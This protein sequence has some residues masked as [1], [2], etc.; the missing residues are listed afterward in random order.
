MSRRILPI[1]WITLLAVLL[2]ACGKPVP[3]DKSAYVGDWQSATMMLRIS[4]EGRVAYR[5]VDGNTRTSVDAPL[6]GFQGDDFKA[7]L[8]PIATT[9]KVSAPPHQD[10]NAWKMTVDGVELTRQ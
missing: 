8:G 6:Q 1:L 9:F 3:A 10:G 4:Q 2:A 5:R 7:G